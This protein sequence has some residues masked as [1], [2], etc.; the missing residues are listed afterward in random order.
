[1]FKKLISSLPFSPALVGQ[2]G[3][4]AKRLKKEEATR[5]LGL[6]FTAL[7]LLVQSFAVFQAPEAANAASSND[8]VYGGFTTREQFLSNYDANK[9]NLK[10][11]LKAVGISRAD[12]VNTAYG[13]W[14]SKTDG[15]YSWGRLSRF[16][17]A[18]GERPYTFPTAGG[19]ST[20]FYYRPL[21]LSDTKTYTI[22][23]GSTYEALVGK[24][25]SGKTF[26]LLKICGNLVL[27]V[28]PPPP[29]C[30]EGKIGTYPN[31]TVPPKMCEVPGKTNLRADDP[32]C[33]VDMCTVIGKTNLRADSPYCKL[34]VC[35]VPGKTNLPANDPNCKLDPVAS[36]ESLKIDKIASNYQFTATAS[37]ANG[38]TL[39]SYTYVVKRDGKVVETKTVESSQTSNI[40]VYNQSKE[41]AYTVELTV[42]TSAGDKTSADCVKTFN[43]AP[44]EM[45]PQN[46]ELLKISPEC[47]PCPGDSTLW[48]KDEK[49]KAELVQTKSAINVTQGNVDATSVTAKASD[50]II[51]KLHI[52]NTGKA[53]LET[54][55][56]ERID[57][58]LEYAVTNNTDL[59]GG[60]QGEDPDTKTAIIT[61]PKVTVKPG[62]KITRMFTVQVMSTIPA[63]NKGVSDAT[64]YDCRMMN[65]FG[66]NTTIAVDCPIQKEIVES[67]TTE[68]PHTGPTENMIMGGG[69]LAV[70]AFFYAR[71]RQLK[72]EVRL[73]RRDF[74]AGTI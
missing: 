35:A 3:F 46:L 55:I 2:L 28:T 74:N 62:E 49:C 43:I 68:L 44:P 53:P 20:T 37:V 13:K 73:I 71:A 1:M 58:V 18:Q 31:C 59:G 14:N 11:V 25:S 8:M 12:I 45:C 33:K 64:S 22:A 70:V 42:N 10:D 52:E 23:N 15:G 66:N 47:Q 65:T 63:V 50:R 32:N 51:Y 24:T 29:P 39:K 48:I 60:T 26:A 38:A 4:Y 36:C 61:W 57:D 34:D 16:S 21:T 41:G 19:G 69:V 40:Y 6:I 67:I 5:K 27:K 56:I 17:Y 72:T 30:P 9:D 54:S 7:A